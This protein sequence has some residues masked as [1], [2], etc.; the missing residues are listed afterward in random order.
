LLKRP[1]LR[2][3]ILA[4]ICAL[5]ITPF[6]RS[7][8]PSGHDFE[9]HMFSWMEVLAQ[10]KQ[11][12]VYPR[13]AALAHWGYGE[14]RFLFYPPESWTLGALLGAL[15]PW[16]IV[17][18]AFCW[19]VLTLAGTSMYRL[20]R[21]W[22]APPDALFAAVFY[23]VNPYHLVI[24]YWRSAY[25]ELLAAAIIPLMLLCL[26]RLKERG[27]R[28]TIWLALALAAA[29]LAN[30]PA[31]LMIHFSA[32]GLA[33]LI[34]LRD[35]SWQP[36][37]KTSLAVLLG[38]GLA[39]FYLVPAIY[40]QPWVNISQVLSPGV[41][42]VDNFLFTT[43]AD[44][45]H[46]R[47]NR[48]VSLVG[49]AEIVVLAA[50][51]WLARRRQAD[52]AGWILLSVWACATAFLMLSPSNF[53][54]EYLPKLRYVQLPFRWLLCLNVPLAILLAMAT[55][56]DG[57]QSPGKRPANTMK[58]PF[59]WITRSIASGL[60][61]FVVLL[62]APR[63]Q[64]AWWD[65]SSD[66]DLMHE[67]VL[68]GGGYEGTD[69]YVPI[70]ADPYELKINLPQVSDEGAADVNP[71]ILEWSANK[72]HFVVQTKGTR[73][74]T[75]RLFNYPA[76][77]VFV[78][79]QPTEAQTSDV[80]GLIIVPVQPGQNDVQIIFGSTPD[81]PIGDA[82]SL[83]SIIVLGVAWVKTKR[84]LPDAPRVEV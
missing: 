52:K 59:R 48:L 22:L 74:L 3:L 61:L 40:E 81:R 6:F 80:T 12:I 56:S 9:F 49:L 72:R 30:L 18:G 29:W 70:G 11:G 42:P 77:K 25:A 53:L 20:A 60:L 62:G 34:A 14:A 26:F 84:T 69:E 63:I 38:A 71:Q 78:N 65:A 8:I 17:P 51:M 44:P 5:T 4:A 13:W 2:V 28:T 24:V 54:W 15:L 7:G 23:A 21:Q 55:R 16:K 73:S 35:R 83:I 1:I 79:G 57:A 66:I 27:F 43:I 31:A 82:L 32:A 36:L 76:W 68:N 64:P 19:L 67:A 45:D 58:P 47:F 46:N 50:A 10:W 75:V 37:L 33:A 39:S 41:R